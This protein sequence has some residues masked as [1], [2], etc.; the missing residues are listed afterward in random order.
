MSGPFCTFKSH[1]RQKIFVD[2]QMQISALI[3]GTAL[4]A[5]NAL[6]NNMYANDAIP[7]LCVYSVESIP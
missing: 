7:T 2:L 5:S 4:S 3:L 6:V 1:P